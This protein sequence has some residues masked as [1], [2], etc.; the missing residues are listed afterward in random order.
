MESF[1]QKYFILVAVCFMFF[2][3]GALFD[4]ENGRYNVTQKPVYF[5]QHS[6]IPILQ[7]NKEFHNFLNKPALCT[8]AFTS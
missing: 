5:R 4:T 8:G 1:Y 3:N 6:P 2:F 7:M